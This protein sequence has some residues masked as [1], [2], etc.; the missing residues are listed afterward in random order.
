M[1]DEGGWVGGEGAEEE[2][3]VGERAAGGGVGGDGAD[4]LEGVG[5]FE[6]EED[7]TDAGE[8]GDDA[9]GDDGEFRGEGGDG[10][11]A[12]VGLA[13]EESLGALRGL[14]VVEGVAGGEIVR[15]GRVL[16]VPHE[17]SRVEEV[18]G[19]YADGMRGGRH[20]G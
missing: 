3:G 1:R 12:E 4:G 7:G 11:E 6:D 2:F 19:G 8:R 17:G 15:E 9:A 13:V 14:D 5:L 18:D 20:Q 16:E 10:D